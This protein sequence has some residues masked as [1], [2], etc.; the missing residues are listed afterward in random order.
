MDSIEKIILDVNRYGFFGRPILNYEYEKKKDQD[1][2]FYLEIMNL[3]G[4][5]NHEQVI[6]LLDKNIEHVSNL[7]IYYLLLTIKMSSLYIL[8]YEEHLSIFNSLYMNLDKIP[9][10][11]KKI[12]TNAL[13][14]LNS[15]ILEK[16][17]KIPDDYHKDLFLHSNHMMVKARGTENPAL[18]KQ[19]H[20]ESIITA[21]KIPNPSLIIANLLDGYRACENPKKR[22]WLL[23]TA[24]YYSS[25]YFSSENRIIDIYDEYLKY[26]KTRDYYRYITE[27]FVLTKSFSKL[28][29][30]QESG[31]AEV[32]DLDLNK[33]Y[34]RN[35]QEVQNLFKDYID[36]F[37]I[38]K[39][40]K[41]AKLGKR[42]AHNIINGKSD[43]V[44]A[45]TLYELFQDDFFQDKNFYEI[46]VEKF[47]S[48][49]DNNIEKFISEIRKKKSR[50]FLIDLITIM[51]TIKK[52]NKKVFRNIYNLILN[53]ED[54]KLNYNEKMILY[55]IYKDYSSIFLKAKQR[56]LKKTF[57]QF[58][59]EKLVVFY[60]FFS[61]K[62]DFKSRTM[63]TILLENISRLQEI[64]MK[65]ETTLK[66]P[67]NKFFD[68]KDV[69]KALW[70]FDETQRKKLVTLYNNMIEK[71]Y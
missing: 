3:Y 43:R 64:N 15:R 65:I 2:I 14:S 42:A 55:I 25:Y 26:L 30:L 70:Y 52:L 9:E 19:L 28:N 31:D 21:K 34:Y 36:S 62:I 49:L 67:D 33:K 10:P 6:K 35:T 45:K 50:D 60:E 61:E 53:N 71:L 29:T 40:S 7:N 18:K 17:R 4:Q 27:L 48:Y 44:H 46:S 24:V 63:L 37:G 47:K 1:L 41:K 69:L 51:I 58:D 32:F 8:N 12:V 68:K 66:I 23:R 5:F 56:L 13:I 57:K 20:L 59:E 39:F 11:A 22:Y 38:N 16:S 54:L